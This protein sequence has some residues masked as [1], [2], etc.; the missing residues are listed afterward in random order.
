MTIPKPEKSLKVNYKKQLKHITSN[1]KRTT[2]TRSPTFVSFTLSS[3]ASWMYLLCFSTLWGMEAT[4]ERLG[5][6][7]RPA[8]CNR[9]KHSL[10]K[11][12][13]SYTQH[14][15]DVWVND[16]AYCP[17]KNS[18]DN[19]RGIFSPKKEGELLYHFVLL[20]GLFSVCS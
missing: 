20:C 3:I 7:W 16:N 4:A 12:S 11:D 10:T 13:N 18:N 6:D 8:D 9:A 2:T 19:K 14:G 17:V 15:R 5:E 1:H